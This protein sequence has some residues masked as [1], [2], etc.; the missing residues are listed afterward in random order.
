[1]PA[2]PGAEEPSDLLMSWKMHEP[3]RGAGF[4][5]QGRAVSTRVPMSRDA[6][7]KSA[8]QECLRHIMAQP[9]ST[10]S[11][12][13]RGDIRRSEPE[14]GGEDGTIVFQ[15]QREIDAVP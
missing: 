14:V 11:S 9:L 1:M 3:S 6:A 8:W 7:G 5:L 12:D 2:F 4:S 13:H 15:G 10:V